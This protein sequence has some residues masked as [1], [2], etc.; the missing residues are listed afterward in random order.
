MDGGTTRNR[1][2]ALELMSLGTAAIVLAT[3]AV[4]IEAPKARMRARPNREELARLVRL[5]GGEF[6]GGRRGG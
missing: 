6:G 1:R 2:Q 4:E 3:P 5:Y